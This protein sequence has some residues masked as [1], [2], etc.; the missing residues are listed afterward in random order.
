LSEVLLAVLRGYVESGQPVGS[1]DAREHSGLTVSPATV[2]GAMG[3]L[4]DPAC[5]SSRTP[6]PVAC[7]LDAA[8]GSGSISCSILQPA[9]R[10]ASS[11]ASSTSRARLRTSRAARRMLTHVTGQL[12]FAFALEASACAWR[13]C[14]SCAARATG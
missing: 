7:R 13:V 14:A 4:M 12:G 6:R 2:R 9:E 10:A 8:S 3:E 11:R 5:S 1:R